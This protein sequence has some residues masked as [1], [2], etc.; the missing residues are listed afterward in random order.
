MPFLSLLRLRALRFTVHVT[1]KDPVAALF[2]AYADVGLLVQISEDPAWL[3][4]ENTSKA[5]QLLRQIPGVQ[6]AVPRHG[7]AF[8]QQVAVQFVP[9]IA[10]LD[11]AIG[12]LQQ[13]L[14][15]C[16]HVVNEVGPELRTSIRR[17]V[18]HISVGITRST[19]KTVKFLGC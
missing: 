16:D 14:Y 4:A 12:G 7:E 8:L 5:Q 11:N 9:P 13:L 10:H 6:F 17:G 1:S 3:V 2:G 19:C 15:G 18:Q